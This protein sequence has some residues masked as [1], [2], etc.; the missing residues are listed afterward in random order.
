[1]KDKIN[2]IHEI[3]EIGELGYHKKILTQDILEMINK[4]KI[5]GPTIK[6]K[7]LLNN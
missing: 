4:E 3:R 7:N 2:G 1:M 5:I 6:V